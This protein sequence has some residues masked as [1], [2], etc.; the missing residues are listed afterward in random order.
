[1]VL[2]CTVGRCLP[3]TSDSTL[4]ASKY[5]IL[6][7]LTN[8]KQNKHPIMAVRL[9]W[10][11]LPIHIHFLRWVI[12]TRKVGQTDLVFGACFI[13]MSVH[14][15]LQVSVCSSYELDHPD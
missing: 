3:C 15:R 13:I 8:T 2:Q 5:I 14:E 11:Q 9:S 4:Q 10:L 7:Y 6:L 1:M 12:L